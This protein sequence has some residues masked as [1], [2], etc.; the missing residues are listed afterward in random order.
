[1]GAN[2][3]RSHYETL[4]VG[5]EATPEAVRRAYRRQA[6]KWHPDRLPGDTRAQRQMTL[7]N[8][9]YA[10]LS[11]AESRAGYDRWLQARDARV[12]AEQAARQARSET[13]TWPWWLLAATLSFAALAIGTVLYKTSVPQVAAMPLQAATR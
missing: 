8:E 5:H 12:A 13:V 7:I 10:V 1:M 9:A 2:A 11:H 6:Q 4:R 3:Q